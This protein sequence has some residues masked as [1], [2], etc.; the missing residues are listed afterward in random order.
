M[1]HEPASPQRRE[2]HSLLINVSTLLQEPIGAER[3][4]D[5][6]D[7]PFDYEGQRRIDGALQLLRTDQSLLARGRLRTTLDDICGGCLAPLTLELPLEFDEEF[8]PPNDALTG[9]PIEAPPERDGFAVLNG[10][11]DLTEVVRQYV[12]MTRPISPR[13]A[14]DCPG[15]GPR[16]DAASADA[17]PQLDDRWAAL[18][19]LREQLNRR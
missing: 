8:W 6:A 12:E 15:L 3:A 18:A 14:A 1:T 13:C 19:P 10:Q 7:A 11:I 5:I 16:V 2:L 17:E 4:Y 9:R